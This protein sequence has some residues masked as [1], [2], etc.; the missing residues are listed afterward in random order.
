MADRTLRTKELV[1]D[2]RSG[3]DR[4][5]LMEKYR[6][7]EAQ[8][9]LTYER[10]IEKGAIDR[11]E[12]EGSRIPSPK[13][14]EIRSRFSDEILFSGEFESPT[15]L[16]EEAVRVD[17]GL[18]GA[19]L[20]R[21]LLEDANLP[22]ASLPRVNLSGADLSRADLSGANLADSDLR[23]STLTKASLKGADLTNTDISAANLDGADLSRA[24]L[25]G[26]DLRGTRANRANFAG[27]DF[28]GANL[29]NADLSHSNLDSAYLTGADM[30]GTKFLGASLFR[31]VKDRGALQKAE[32]RKVLER[33]IYSPAKMGA[34]QI[35]C[36]LIQTVMFVVAGPAMLFWLAGIIALHMYL[37]THSSPRWGWGV[38]IQVGYTIFLFWLIHML[39]L[40]PG[41]DGGYTFH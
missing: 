2:I 23:G 6:L 32:R 33:F 24:N 36:F 3:M 10:L 13:R 40:P 15:R 8:L 17:A 37:W 12:L 35:F 21:L 38:W 41:A 30:D 1:E 39:T 26:G 9:Q 22:G 5:A 31:V 27:A 20:S 25:T 18:A 19:D 4:H 34:V 28:T 29:S 16:L 14:M 11:A 7:S